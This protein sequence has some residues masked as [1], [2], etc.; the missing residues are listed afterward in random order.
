MPKVHNLAVVSHKAIL[1]DTVEIGPFCIVEDN[2]EIG[3]GTVLES[4]VVVKSG[5]RMGTN[6]YVA[7]GAILGG[8]PQ[9]RN[10]DPSISTFLVIGDRNTIRE[11]VTL[12]RAIKEGLATRVGNDNYLMAKSHLGHDGTIGNNVTIAN[13]VELAGHVTVE[14]LVT[15][16]GLAGFHQF[17]RI[18][19]AAM[20]QGMS[21]IGRDVPPF[22]ITAERDRIVDINAVGLRRSGVSQETRLALHKAVK[23]LF[24]S[25]LGLTN[26]IS[27]VRREVPQTPEVDY[28]L[29]FEER[30]FNGKNGRGD[31]P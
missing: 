6:N 21:G 4:H 29:A 18:G 12:H 14:D 28:L 26:A 11:Y 13:S 17:V 9:Y 24:K 20:L 2:V 10:F 22:T 31:Q 16:G 30:R 1:A 25:E 27:I 7:Q 23:I 15:I 3:E 19:R 5:T 8:Y